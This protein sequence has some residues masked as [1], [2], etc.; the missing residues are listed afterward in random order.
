VSG[1]R[2]ARALSLR[3]YLLTLLPFV[4]VSAAVAVI[5]LA[6]ARPSPSP[7]VLLRSL[8]PLGLGLLVAAVV[9]TVLVRRIT[10][11]MR[12]QQELLANV[13]HELRTPLARIRVAL[14]LLDVDDPQSAP[15]L[16]QIAADL[17]EL[18]KLFAG[19][20]MT[21]R[22]D[23]GAGGGRAASL[24]IQRTR[25]EARSVLDAT[26][27]LFRDRHPARE[28]E[29]CF[30]DVLPEIDAD[31]VLLR[32]VMDNMLDNARKYSEADSVV[33]LR[34]RSERGRLVVEVQDRGI[35]IA[36]DDLDKLFRPFFRTDQSRDR[37]TGG[38]GLGLTLS[39]RIIEAHGGEIQIESERGKGTR[40]RFWVPALAPGPS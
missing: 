18:E 6:L 28:L 23:L 4:V 15:E 8:M 9:A 32:R 13:S 12:A 22:L 17:E 5:D 38:M 24:P 40:V 16:R 19:I 20:M 27:A 7:P 21:A 35:G 39:R 2:P 10:R 31:P 36:R 37:A 25:L 3:I 1:R 26:V 29:I 34:A 30:E 11:L 33:T 14:D